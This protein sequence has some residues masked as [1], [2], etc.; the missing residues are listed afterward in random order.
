MG[1]CGVVQKARQRVWEEGAGSVGAASAA[2][3]FTAYRVIH[4]LLS[5]HFK[6]PSPLPPTQA[7]PSAAVTFTAYEVILG[8]LLVGA[9][10]SQARV[11]AA[12]HER[13]TGLE[14]VTEPVVMPGASGG[15]LKKGKGPG[16][17]VQ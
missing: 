6:I 8:W 9:A 11:L 10:T 5:L 14:A 1:K 7:A 13:H 12:R 2:V 16:G 17:K 3:T 15:E 4:G